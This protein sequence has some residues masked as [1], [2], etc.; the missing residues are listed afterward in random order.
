MIG[1]HESSIPHERRYRAIDKRMI[2]FYTK[3]LVGARKTFFVLCV[4]TLP[5]PFTYL[6][7]C[8]ESLDTS[9]TVSASSSK[10][11]K[12]SGTF[13]LLSIISHVSLSIQ[14]PPPS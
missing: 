13:T 12:H 8:G 5:C 14:F 9:A 2:V 11:D 1:I 4:F 7:N 3:S 6:I 10:F